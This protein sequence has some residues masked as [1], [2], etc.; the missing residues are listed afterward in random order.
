MGLGL[1]KQGLP[2]TLVFMVPR[3]MGSLTTA[4]YDSCHTDITTSG[5]SRSSQS[6]ITQATLLL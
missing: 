6:G 1:G 3:S 4:R 5:R 2:R